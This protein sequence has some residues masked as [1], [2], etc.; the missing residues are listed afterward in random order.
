MRKGSAGFTLIELIVVIVIIGI[1]A[2]I[3]IPKFIDL[4]NQAKAAATKASL[5]AVRS[6]L[7]M[8]YAETAATG[9][10]AWPSSLVA[11]D[12][13]NG[14]LPLNQCTASTVINPVASAPAATGTDGFWFITTGA[15]AGQA[16]AYYG[17]ATGACTG[18]ASW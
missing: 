15:S 4:T 3:A 11:A 1:L 17:T 9:T 13:A 7:Y 6:T 18:A 8:K 12:F 16:G 5:G 10:A 2:I 14:T